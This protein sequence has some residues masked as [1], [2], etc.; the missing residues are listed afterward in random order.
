M[1][2]PQQARLYRNQLEKIHR[3]SPDDE[4]QLSHEQRT[5]RIVGHAIWQ[6]RLDADIT[7]HELASR[8][9]C[10]ASNIQKIEHGRGAPSI[11][12]L[13]RIAESIGVPASML[14]DDQRG[15]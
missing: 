15:A 14:I 3:L 7:R 9:G 4:R 6:A 13:F 1:P 2:T 11:P 8:V 10:S 5:Y 12:L